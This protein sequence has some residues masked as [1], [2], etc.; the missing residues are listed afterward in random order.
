MKLNIVSILLFISFTMNGQVAS[1]S[2]NEL[3]ELFGQWEGTLSYT[4]YS[5]DSSTS[6]LKCKMI[7][8]WK[9]RKGSIGIGFTEPNGKVIY[10]IVK[11]KLLKK[12]KKIKFD[13]KKYKVDYFKQDKNSK[14]WE[15]IMSCS[16]KDN[17]RKATIKQRIEYNDT[18]LLI[19]KEV[20]YEGTSDFFER[21]KY[22]LE[23]R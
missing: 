9:G 19:T 11:M 10:D 13:G 8:Y 14:S 12:G 5:D 15:L 3:Q 17:N 2:S 22:T 1:V 4:D 6:T 23:R 20:K 18:T 16:G 21:S 7:I